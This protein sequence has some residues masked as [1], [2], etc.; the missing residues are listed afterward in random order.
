M[1]EARETNAGDSTKMAGRSQAQVFNSDVNKHWEWEGRSGFVVMD[2]L[3]SEVAGDSSVSKG[4]WL[5]STET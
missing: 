3:Q 4:D 5:Q 2:I 1:T